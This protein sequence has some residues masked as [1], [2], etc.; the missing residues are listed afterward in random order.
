[1]LKNPE[2]EKH[3]SD[4]FEMY[5]S[6]GW[7]RLQAQ[8]A[9]MM[10]SNNT[11]MGLNTV[12]DLQFRKGELSMMVHIINHQDMHERA[13]NEL[14]ETETGTPAEAPTGGVAKV[15]ETPEEKK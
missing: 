13:Y 2:L 14:V 10:K 15:V 9:E 12:E 11:L 1:M 4:L 5:G 7:Q 8:F 6:A 3:Y